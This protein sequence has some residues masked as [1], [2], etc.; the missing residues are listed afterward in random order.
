MSKTKAEAEVK[1]TK[2]HKKGNT[3]MKKKKI[4]KKM[5]EL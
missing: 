2:G 1:M 5:R 4:K 3:G